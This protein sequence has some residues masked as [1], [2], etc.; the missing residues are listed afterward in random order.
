[1]NVFEILREQV[2]L[3]RVLSANGS[4]K[5]RCVALHHQDNDPYMHVY[6][7]H[8]NCYGCGFRG[9]VV[10]VWSAQKGIIR[11]IEAA[12]DLAREFNVRLPEISEEAQQKSQ[13]VA[14]EA[15]SAAKEE[16]EKQGL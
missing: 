6:E 14:E 9:D 12:F 7:D 13:Q 3:Q 5:V 10:D 2:T 16:A 11:P 4:A 8:V 1:M 15:Q